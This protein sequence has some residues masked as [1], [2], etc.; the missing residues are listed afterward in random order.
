MRSLGRPLFLA[1]AGLLALARLS[2]AAPAASAAPAAEESPKF[3]IQHIAVEG[4][5]REA[6]GGLIVHE[7]FLEEGKSY[8]ERELREAVYR[9]KRLPFI[10]NAD[11]SLRR[12]TERGTY[13]LVVA[14]Q[15]TPA[16]FFGREETFLAIADDSA[17]YALGYSPYDNLKAAH[18]G[19]AGARLFLG[20]RGVLFG[21]L[22]GDEAFQVG[23]TQ[24]NLFGTRAVAS[25][26]VA[27]NI[28]CPQQ[29]V[30]LGL[31]PGANVLVTRESGL[32][33]GSLTVPLSTNQS[34]RTNLS[35]S[36]GEPSRVHSLLG[37]TGF[38]GLYYGSG[39]GFTRRQADVKWVYDTADDP[40]FPTAGVTLSGGLEIGDLELPQ[41]FRFL[42][43][44]PVPA[45]TDADSTARM[46]AL[47]VAGRRHWSLTPRQ[48]F[49]AGLRTA[50]GRSR[51]ENLEVDGRL[52]RQ[53]DLT[54]LE[55][56]A[57]LRYSVSLWKA[58]KTRE[59]GDLRLETTAGYS[60]EAVTP[61][62][63]AD[64]LG[65]LQLGTSVAFR[66][67][68]GVFRAGFSYLD[69]DGGAR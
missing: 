20:S 8:S 13:E 66:N 26:S 59:R 42:G 67:R 34:L 52:I 12:G 31:D 44:E 22:G 58:G 35:W 4:T 6:S 37:S 30:P 49:S 53:E 21:A 69:F 62:L 41:P 29:A 28:C 9:V 23:Y 51:V 3:L 16:F 50:V 7:S 14:V 60:Y 45:L 15:E 68:W 33:S 32:L 25:A 47:A 63:G 38:E 2:P 11:F 17:S 5:R 54:T 65:R 61:G 27:R 56:A 43:A 57:D 55:G 24:Y 64:H 46:A 18:S 36:Q 19:V 39:E 48:S 10:V 1:L 40:L